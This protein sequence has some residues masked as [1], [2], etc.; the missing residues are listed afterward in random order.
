MLR[1]EPSTF[2]PRIHG[3]P[4]FEAFDLSWAGY[5][6]IAG[7]EI[8][9]IQDIATPQYV[10]TFDNN[11]HR[12][13]LAPAFDAWDAYTYSEFIFA[14]TPE[15][16]FYH[17]DSAALFVPTRLVP[18]WVLEEMH[19]PELFNHLA[20]YNRYFSSM[21]APVFLVTFLAFF[22]MQVLIFVAMVWLFGH[23]QKLS[24]NMS[25]RERFQV[26]T[27]ASV[28]AGILGFAMGIIMPVLHI[29]VFQMVLIYCTYKAMKE[30]WNA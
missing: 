10:M 7:D 12:V 11:G 9:F 20:L 25:I 14:I 24:G 6:D 29:F 13:V 16:I 15:Y 23:W 30:F 18:V 8:G 19:L 17:D 22:A 21:V 27:F 1:E 4:I 28:P 26:C 2:F 5:L 3:G